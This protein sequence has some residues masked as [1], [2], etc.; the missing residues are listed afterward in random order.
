MRK[1]RAELLGA[2][3]YFCEDSIKRSPELIASA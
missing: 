2:E 3:K 1:Q